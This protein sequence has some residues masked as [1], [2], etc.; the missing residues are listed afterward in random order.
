MGRVAAAVAG[1]AAAAVLTC[2]ASLGEP[3]LVLQAPG[4]AVVG[5][6][7]VACR[8]ERAML[9]VTVTNS[10]S[11]RVTVRLAVPA[12]V[13]GGSAGIERRQTGWRDVVV[14]E[15]ETCR[16]ERQPVYE[17][18]DTR[19]PVMARFSV[20]P[21]VSII[22]AGATRQFTVALLNPDE[23]NADF[24]LR[25]VTRVDGGDVLEIVAPSVRW[26]DGD[27]ASAGR[28]AAP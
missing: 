3:R 28:S 22:E 11:R 24:T 25:V 10:G 23:S 19:S 8:T 6:L 21:R 16:V 18:V 5:D 17:L 13:I 9:E 20:T 12:T 4:E 2:C 14:C 26:L 15:G 7:E 1:L 27:G